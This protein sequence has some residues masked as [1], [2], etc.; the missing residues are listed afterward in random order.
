MSADVQPTKTQ[1][2]E[3]LNLKPHE[4]CNG[5][6]AETFRDTSIVL[7]RSHLPPNCKVD[8]H[9][10]TC[11]YFLLPSGHLSYFHRTTCAQTFHFYLGEPLT[12]VELNEKD[13]TFKVTCVGP[14]VITRD[15]RLQHTVPPNVWFGSI[16]TKDYI[17][18][19]DG[20]VKALISLL[21]SAD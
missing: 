7:P 21:T 3:R 2:V 1:I 13:G 4:T 16:P 6:F 19:S 14:D 11:I 10:S 12:V 18:S 5:Y 20:V 9:V 15:H 8:H 17:I